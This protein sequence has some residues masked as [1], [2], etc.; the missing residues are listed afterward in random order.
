MAIV[1]RNKRKRCFSECL[2]A[3]STYLWTASSCR[4][5]K[6][7]K[8]S[9][10]SSLRNWTICNAKT[11]EMTHKRDEENTVL[12]TKRNI[13]YCTRRK[14]AHSTHF[15]NTY[16]MKAKRQAH[17]REEVSFVPSHHVWMPTFDFWGQARCVRKL[18][19]ALF[20]IS[21]HT[22]KYEVSD[23]SNAAKDYPKPLHHCR[24]KMKNSVVES[25]LL[26]SNRRKLVMW[27]ADV[28]HNNE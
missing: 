10:R 22:K 2:T 9:C 8:F 4:E 15:S 3:V 28:R 26:A 19:S 11:W 5:L 12:S 23:G 27:S 14:T 6:Q 25:K 24:S 18:W 17:E 16:Q 13:L 1:E 20:S 7:Q 21:N